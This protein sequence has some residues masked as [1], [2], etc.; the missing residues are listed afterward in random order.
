LS[1]ASPSPAR[2]RGGGDQRF[3]NGLLTDWA[4]PGQTAREAGGEAREER[5]AEED[6]WGPRHQTVNPRGAF[7]DRCPACRRDRP[8]HARTDARTRVLAEA[9]PPGSRASGS[10]SIGRDQGSWSE[11]AGRPGS[12]GSGYPE[13]RPLAADGTHVPPASA[14]SAWRV[15]P[16][17]LN[18]LPVPQRD[19]A[20]AMW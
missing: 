4:T 3:A 7:Q 13:A 17:L 1:R 20:A 2:S 18:A 19:A 15:R 5:V 9:L 8:Q 6:R 14:D 12:R 10:P 11:A 16:R